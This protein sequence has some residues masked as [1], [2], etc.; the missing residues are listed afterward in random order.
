M[1]TVP[2]ARI[3]VPVGTV[4]VTPELTVKLVHCISA[5]GGDVA[6]FAELA[7]VQTPDVVESEP[8]P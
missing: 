6:Q 5:V 7:I 3:K 4:S 1:L 2:V 8:S